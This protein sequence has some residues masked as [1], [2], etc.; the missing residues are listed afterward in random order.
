M[1]ENA[2]IFLFTGK[3]FIQFQPANVFDHEYKMFRNAVSVRMKMAS[4]QQNMERTVDKCF[5]P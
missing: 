5:Q 2:S 1:A 3:V 4:F